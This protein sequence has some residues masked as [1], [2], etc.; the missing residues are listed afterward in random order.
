M[1]YRQ[2]SIVALLLI[3]AT[4]E[5][6][7]QY[8]GR[9]KPNYEKFDF[10]VVET[11]HFEIHHYLKDTAYLKDL[12][13][14]CE[15]WYHIHQEALEDTIAKKNP[16]IFYN[17]H[18]DFQQ[19]NTVG[20]AIGV[21]TG[22][23]T[24][25]LKNRVVMPLAMS[26]QQTNHVLGHE[27]VHAFQYNMIINGDSTNLKNL[28]NIPLW[29]VEGLAEYM[30]I[31]R[32]D[33][34]TSMWMRDAVLNEDVPSIKA[35]NRGEYFPYRYGQAFWAFLT[36]WKGDDIIEPFF[37]ATA[38]YGF[39][40]ACLS[41]LKTSSKNVSTL[42]Q[43]A[44]KN[45]YDEMMSAKEERFIGKKLISEANSGEMNIAPVLS[46]N[47]RHLI[48]L[49]EKNLFTTD[50][51]LADARTGK[52]IRKVSSRASDG[53]I[54]DYSY[55]ESAGT[56][57][58]RSKQFAFVA[59]SQGDNIIVIKEVETGKTIEEFKIPGLPAF[60]NPAWSPDG[61]SLV[62]TAIVD[63][64]LDLYQ[65][66]LKSKKAKQLTNSRYSEI[67]PNWSADGKKITFATDEL[68][69]QRG[70]THGKWTYNIAI[71]DVE[72]GQVENID[73]FAGADSFNPIFDNKGNILFLSN[74]DGFRNMYQYETAT[75]KVYQMT[76]LLTGISGITPF[77][78][79]IS[80]TRTEKRDRILFT[81]FFKGK[82]S[83]YEGD[84]EDFL[85]KEVAT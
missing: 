55:I 72:S 65:V 42:W 84:P 44:T 30:S 81:H 40:K 63:G 25:G 59:V 24:E 56:W 61:K 80:T 18:P 35:L 20:G 57:S 60:S 9:N 74:R 32:V 31:G 62:V 29:M 21:G 36:G 19:T 28:S 1:K 66:N 2:V 78:P 53:H 39:D 71:L 68:S 46:P 3:V 26:N 41:I 70:R 16:L 22:G 67:A 69:M 43:Q 23:V 38:K 8:F 48:F 34:H 47:G 51:F 85:K 49:S 54:D 52:I 45:H 13:K 6:Q 64:Q 50:L 11:P 5:M 10:E 76:D 37:M 12:A 4:V 83:I 15:H 79:A 77:A 7:A 73:I 82:Y 14:D 33:A 17:N 75:A 58:P 27:L